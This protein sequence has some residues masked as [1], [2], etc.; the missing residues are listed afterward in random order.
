MDNGITRD[1]VVVVWHDEEISADK[2]VDTM[3]VTENDPDFPYV[4]KHIVDLTLAQIKTLDCGSKRLPDF[5]L[6][7][8]YPGTKITTLREVF[9]FVQCADPRRN[10]SWN[11]ESKINPILPNNTRGVADFVRRQ[12]KGFVNSS[13]SLS[14]ITYQSF[15]WRTLIAMKELDPRVTTSALID[16]ET[17]IGPDNSTSKW[18]A[19]LRIDNFPGAN[20]GERISNAAASI[21]AGILS[22]DA[23]MSVETGLDPSDPSYIPLSTMKDMIQRSHYLGME[24]K[25]WTV[26]QLNI[27]EQLIDWGVDG[28]ITDYPGIMRRDMQKR[29]KSVA[30][31]YPKR[32][33][34]ECLNSHI[35]K[36]KY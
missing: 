6:Q 18:L 7:L 32:R 12:H 34:L 24:V 11:I 36:Q 22:P 27:A 19:G 20:L 28:I 2:C 3:P 25:P 9:E 21:G 1:G 35:S 13:Y 17:V 29:G 4:G 8:T 10:I 5:P 16:S 26:N 30:P 33:V 15:D 31:K 23:R 14:Q